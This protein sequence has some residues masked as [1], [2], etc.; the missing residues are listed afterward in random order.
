MRAQTL[1][2]N[3]GDRLQKAGLWS[4]MLGLVA[5][6]MTFY[7]GTQDQFELPKQLMLRAVTS[8]TLGLS[9]AWL[10]TAKDVRWRRTP[11]DLPVLAWSL[12]LLVCTVHSVSPTISWRGEYENFA[13]SLT[14]LNYSLLFFLTVQLAAQ[15][16]A[17]RQVA[18]AMLAAATG[19]ALYAVAQS[20]QR[21]LVGWS[22]AS[23]V[24]NRFFGPLGNPNF[25][26]GLM[27][28]AIALKLALGL[29]EQ[30]QA[31]PRDREAPW[32]WIL[33]AGWSLAYLAMGRGSLLDPLLA[34]QGADP[35][36]AVVLLLWLAVLVAAPLLRRQGRP[37][38]AHAL[39]QGADL[40]LYLQA[41]ANT[42]TRGGFLGLMAGLAALVLGWMALRP[43]TQV[44]LRRHLVQAIAGLAAL[45][46]ALALVI[47]ALGPSFR[48]RVLQSLRHPHHALER[49]RLQIWGPALKIWRAHPLAGTGVDTFKT[50]F[51][52]YASARF[53]HY[54]GDNVSSRMAHC[55]P[56]QVLATQGLVGLALWLWLCGALALGAWRAVRQASD[57]AT[58]W[59]WLGLG[60][61]ATAYLAQNLV[62]FGVAAI[63][64]PFWVA[65]GLLAAANAP[66]PETLGQRPSVATPSPHGKAASP[67]PSQ[68][69]LGLAG[70]LLAGAL[71]AGGGLGLDGQ[72]LR[73]DLDF[74]F[75]NQA[76]QSLSFIENDDLDTCRSAANWALNELQNAALNPPLAEETGLWRQAL[77]TWERQLA[78]TPARAPELLPL[79]RRADGALLMILA[80]SSAQAATDLCPDEVKYQ[81]YVGLAYEELY[82]RTPTDRRRLWFAAAE[83]AYQK[84]EALNPHNAYYSGNLGRIYGMAFDAGEPSYYPKAMAAYQR[85]IDR[86]PST[87]LFYEN[88]LLL[89]AHAADLDGAQHILDRVRGADQYLAPPVEM[90]AAGTFLQWRNSKTPAWTPQRRSLAL[91]KA[92]AWSLLAQAGAPDDPAIALA[93][94][95]IQWA[96][97]QRDQAQRCLQAALRASP[98]FPAALA[99]AQQTG[100]RP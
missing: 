14:Q 16:D 56:L 20:L 54:D 41:L 40:L 80:A 11:L 36:S 44:P 99:W 34:R 63:S 74:A 17:A 39:A 43:A 10:L 28:M 75:A 26:A 58:R 55:E 3:W 33:L 62:S 30:R 7:T 69:R 25:L 22:A 13:G 78:A 46:L 53:N 96:T 72:T 8:L 50:V 86:A 19:A 51:P 42:G 83:Q 52:A 57:E 81:L 12:W 66:Q 95:Q 2:P 91:Q 29:A 70:A 67:T 85:A 23:V 64:V 82:R 77:A 100:L 9:V 68:G 87:K 98:G 15:R 71:L 65:A 79:Y 1:A 49:S 60:A 21:D 88:A 32:R 97:G 6:T 61:F 92:A 31:V 90:A 37:R 4:L 93:T 5:V 45:G 89:Q 48:S 47:A 27:A 35:V 38:L 24:S 18:V 84:A 59:L 94:A 73:A 76:V